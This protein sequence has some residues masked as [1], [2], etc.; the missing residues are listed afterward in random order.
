MEKKTETL[1]L[2]KIRK[3]LQIEDEEL[4]NKYL[5]EIWTELSKRSKEEFI[6]GINKVTFNKY[7]DLPGIIS[8]RIFSV[9]DKDKDGI[10]SFSE[11]TDGMK[12]IFSQTQTFD[13]LSKFIFNFYDFR[14]CNK[15]KKED[16]RVVLSYVPLQKND[17]ELTKE[18]NIVIVE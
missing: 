3:S 16:V 18:D 11:F 12:M 15:I 2:A 17:I 8:E 5:K 7:Y 4:L 14:S 9:F 10:L 13:S 1:D 6:Q